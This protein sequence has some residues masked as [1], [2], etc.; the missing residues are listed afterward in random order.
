MD[1]ELIAGKPSP[2][3]LEWAAVIASEAPGPILDAPSGK[4][5]NAIPFAERGCEVICADNN[6]TSLSV[7]TSYSGDDRLIGALR[8]L[9]VD[10]LA[11][12]LPFSRESLGAVI[13][14][15]FLARALPRRLASFVRSGGFVYIESYENRGGNYLEL[16]RAGEF[17]ELFSD[18]EL[19]AY[20]EKKAGPPSIDAVTFH[21][22]ARK[23]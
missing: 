19:L 14:V 18:F 12:D 10:L 2:R 15:H 13:N 8:P 16:P 6:R 4:G 5:R 1:I 11:V 23:R 7:I 9:E 3:L 21:C 20:S 17:R 22:L